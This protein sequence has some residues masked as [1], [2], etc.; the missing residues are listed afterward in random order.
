LKAI[1]EE[2]FHL[3]VFGTIDSFSF[4]RAAHTLATLH[5]V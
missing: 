1:H 3:L 4:S 2:Q 5:N